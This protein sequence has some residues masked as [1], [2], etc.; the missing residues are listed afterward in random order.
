VD[1]ERDPPLTDAELDKLE[2]LIAQASPAPWIAS[3][4]GRD[5]TSGDDLILVGDPREEDMYV[6]RDGGPASAADLDFIAT[7]RNCMPRLLKELRR[8]RRHS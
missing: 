4:E 6:S 5:H 1:V 3:V 7:A 2:R 8:L